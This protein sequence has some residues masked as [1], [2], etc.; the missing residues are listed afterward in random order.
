MLLVTAERKTSFGVLSALFSTAKGKKKNPTHI[1]VQTSFKQTSFK[2]LHVRKH[3]YAFTLSGKPPHNNYALICSSVSLKR[4]TLEENK[5]FISE[6]AV[7]V[8]SGG[9]FTSLCRLRF[10]LYNLRCL[11]ER[12]R[13]AFAALSMISQVKPSFFIVQLLSFEVLNKRRRYKE[14]RHT[15]GSSGWVLCFTLE[16]RESAA[17][18]SRLLLSH[19]QRC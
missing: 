16:L 5:R 12:A 6:C 18:Y 4:C 13:A 14:C 8:C 19:I 7:Q 10:H 11:N 3:H 17:S 15:L 2:T 1:K 9:V